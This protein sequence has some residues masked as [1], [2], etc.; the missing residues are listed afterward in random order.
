[1]EEEE[2][3]VNKSGESKVLAPVCNIP[4][5]TRPFKGAV[6]LQ[7]SCFYQGAVRLWEN[8]GYELVRDIESSDIV[9][10]LGGADINPAIYGERP[11]GASYFSSEQDAED[12]AAVKKAG[13]RFK[14]GICRGAQLLNCYPNGGSLWQHIDRHGGHH[15]VTDVLTE[16]EYEVNSIH[17]QQM[18]PTDDGEI[19]AFANEATYK[20]REG[21]EWRR[22]DSTDPDIEAV[23]YEKTKSLLVQWHPEVGGADS[24]SYF[25][26]LMERYYLAA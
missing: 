25:N 9:C 24:V 19:L 7:G 21:R 8:A 1:M 11:A 4:D 18:L 20:K 15:K 14:V 23:W 12:I 16:A 26:N 22:G 6:Y 17:H 13:N 3:E 5:L 10:W 2:E